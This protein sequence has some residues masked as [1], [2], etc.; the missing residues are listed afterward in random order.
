M[1]PNKPQNPTLH[2]VLMS[3]RERKIFRKGV[4]FFLSISMA[5]FFTSR[6]D[7]A[8]CFA[9]HLETTISIRKMNQKKQV[10]FTFVKILSLG[11]PR[12]AKKDRELNRRFIIT[13]FTFLIK[14]G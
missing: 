2:I 14:Q 13:K 3:R 4:K 9:F 7:K 8:K 5:L 12:K 10:I 1:Y 11:K 6:D